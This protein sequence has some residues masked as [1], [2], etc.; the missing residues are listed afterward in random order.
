MPKSPK[1]ASSD[2][3][4]CPLC[5]GH[6]HIERTSV[7]TRLSDQEFNR[8]LQNYIDEV[9]YGAMQ[10]RDDLPTGNEFVSVVREKEPDTPVHRLSA[11]VG[12]G[13]RSNKE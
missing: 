11:T 2:V 5:Q 12:F 3:V 13:R 6:G 8:T 9:T 7:V 4:T 10:L 1:P